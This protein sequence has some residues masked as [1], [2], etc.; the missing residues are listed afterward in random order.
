MLCVYNDNIFKERCRKHL[1]KLL[2]L[3]MLFS[4]LQS[5]PDWY[6]IK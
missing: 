5:E 3:A 1:M 4:I 6:V 2:K